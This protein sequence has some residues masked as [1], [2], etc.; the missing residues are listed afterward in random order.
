[1]K[2]I[3][4]EVRS[5]RLTIGLDLGDKS[6]AYCVLD[7]SGAVVSEHKVRTTPKALSDCFSGMAISRIALETGTH[8]PWISR[9]LSGIGHEVIVANARHVRLIAQSRQKDDR[10]DAR[11][12]ARLARVDPKLLSPVTHRSAQAQADLSLIR[13]RAALVRSRATLINTARGLVKTNG[14]RLHGSSSRIIKSD[15]SMDLSPALRISMEPVLQSIKALTL[16]IREYNR[17]IID[18][19]K[20]SYPEVSLLTQVH[21]VGPLVAL[22][23]ILTLEDP[24]RFSK[25]RDAGCYIGLQPAR[26][27]SG[28]C[29]PQLHIT[30][31]GDPY[32]RSLLVE[33]AHHILGP[34]GVDSDLRRWGLAL[35]ARG[36]AL[37][38][39]RAIVGV[40]RRLAVVLHHLW[41][42]GEVYR[43]L[44]QATLAV[45]SAA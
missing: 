17:K 41:V 10:L 14:E 32:L 31:E 6:S 21:G 11:T 5:E 4:A 2:T 15:V 38:K 29:Q 25:S 30:K 40:A 7:G 12:L 28:S 22:T 27:N 37:G 24:H 44:H 23:Y 35:A 3:I 16:Q 26:R 13:A 39:K 1:M 19:G 18:L 33:S 36:A 42:T 45:A 9:L 8:S 43:P 20:T 34:F